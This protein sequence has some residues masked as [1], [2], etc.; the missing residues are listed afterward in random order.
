M[1][2]RIGS[3]MLAG[4]LAMGVLI[5]AGGLVT[6]LYTY[7]LQDV[8]AMVLAENV[9]S[10]K[11]AQ[12]LEVALFRMRGLTSN[13]ILDED[14]SWL[15]TLAERKRE[16]QTW[17]EKAKKTA[18]TGI[19]KQILQTISRLFLDYEHNLKKAVELRRTEKTQEAKILL[20]RTSRDEFDK[21]YDQCEAFVAANE[22]YMYAA[23]EKITRTNSAMR[24]AMYGLGAGGILLG[25]ILGWMISRS[26][27]NPIYELG[28]LLPAL[29]TKF[30][31]R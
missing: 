10:L 28:K 18:R 25:S 27:V 30:A 2:L 16:W 8:T 26:I 31:I 17:M 23:Q 1:K 12:E 29:P 7:R 13:Y 21:I 3:K 15:I 14:P 11:V 4:F 20:L 22:N 5:L 6:I 19:E 9:S 24:A